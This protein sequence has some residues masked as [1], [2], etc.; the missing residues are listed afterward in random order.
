MVG[1]RGGRGTEEWLERGG[2]GTGGGGGLK[3]KTE[4]A[5]CLIFCPELSVLSLGCSDF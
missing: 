5:P 2:G 4:N 1:K 3:L